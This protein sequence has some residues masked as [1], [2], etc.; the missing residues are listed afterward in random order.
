MDRTTTARVPVTQETYTSPPGPTAGWE[1]WLHR[2]PAL[3]ISIGV[4]NVRPPSMD[5]EK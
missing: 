1:P 5:R 3:E 4:E 2:Y